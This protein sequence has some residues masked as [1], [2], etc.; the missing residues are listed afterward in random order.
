MYNQLS[1]AKAIVKKATAIIAVIVA[2]LKVTA[3]H[4]IA[5]I[6]LNTTHKFISLKRKKSK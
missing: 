2:K 4:G 5:N 1:V 3:E 6:I